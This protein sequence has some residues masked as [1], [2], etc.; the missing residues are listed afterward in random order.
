MGNENIETLLIAFLPFLLLL[1]EVRDIVVT[2]AGLFSMAWVGRQIYMSFIKRKEEKEKFK[3]EQ[4][5][6]KLQIRKVKRE[7]GED[8]EDKATP[9][10]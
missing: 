8:N 9:E 1:A 10:E 3:H 5:L 6:L 2:G 7:L 4:T